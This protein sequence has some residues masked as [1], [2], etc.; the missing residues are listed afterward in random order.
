MSDLE[1][2]ISIAV[3]AHAGQVDKAG[4]PYILHPL[5]LMLKFNST[6]AMIV[7]VLHDVV[8]DSSI[9][10]QELEGFG[11]S[12][13]V[14][15]AVASLTRKRGESYEDFVVRVSKNELARMVKIEDVKDNLNLT[16]LSTI[17]D[18]DLVR[19][20]K[21]HSALMVLMRG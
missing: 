11:F 7:A 4:Q 5:R 9:M 20:Q 18:K 12:D 21:Y 8:E 13:V 2:A 3:K 14:V 6:D 15:D 16:R 19:I 17:T 1:Q 10:I